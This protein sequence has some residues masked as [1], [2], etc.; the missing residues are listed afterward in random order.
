M[1]LVFHQL[2]ISLSVMLFRP[3]HAVAKG[4]NSEG[5]TFNLS[6]WGTRPLGHP[7]GSQQFLLA[8][9]EREISYI[10]CYRYSS[11]HKRVCVSRRKRERTWQSNAV[12]LGENTHFWGYSKERT[13]MRPGETL[14]LSPPS[15]PLSRAQSA[16]EWLAVPPGRKLTHP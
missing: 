7:R 14:S 8:P 16:S 12:I 6:L 9:S 1:V 3:I 13:P 11:H 2:V 4:K 10:I 5:N 15:F